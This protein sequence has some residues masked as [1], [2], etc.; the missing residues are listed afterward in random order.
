MAERSKDWLKQA[1]RD[2]EHAKMD[3][4]EGY[5]EWACFS[6][7]QAAE[8]ALKALYQSLGKIAWG[9]SI[10]GLLDGLKD[11]F[12]VE[13]LINCAKVLDKYYIPTRYPNGFPSG[14]PS[15]YFT[16]K[17]AKE[18]IENASK[19]IRFCKDNIPE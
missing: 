9:H 10:L 16:E 12:N 13:N 3:L 19:I 4:K 8:K 1:E 2:L 11:E 5:Y 18:A 7:R 15:D 14:S 6:A 17:D